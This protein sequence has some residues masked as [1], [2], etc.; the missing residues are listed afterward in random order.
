[1]STAARAQ[2]VTFR[3][4]EEIFAADIFSV[5]RVLGYVA[6]TPVPELPDWALGVIEYRERVVPVVDLRRRFGLPAAAH[7]PRTRILI[8]A[9]DDAWIGARVDAVLEV[10]SF[11]PDQVTAPPPLFHGLAGHYLRGI[12][13]RGDRLLIFLDVARLLTATERLALR[14]EGAPAHG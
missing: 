4:G 13:R 12:V 10:A 7:E 11:A 14:P 1:M 8:L 2:A 6:P 3:V 9:V 5:E